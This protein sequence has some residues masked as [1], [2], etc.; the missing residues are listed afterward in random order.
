MKLRLRKQQLLGVFCISIILSIN[1]FSQNTKGNKAYNIISEH[2]ISCHNANSN[3]SIPDFTS[4]SIIRKWRSTIKEAILSAYMPPYRAS[5]SSKI[6]SENI[7]DSIEKSNLVTWLD[8]NCKM[9]FLKKKIANKASKNKHVYNTIVKY[10]KP[11]LLSPSN[12]DRF[13]RT[14]NL[15]KLSEASTIK[16]LNF[17]PQLR[18]YIHHVNFAIYSYHSKLKLDTS[19]TIEEIFYSKQNKKI[20]L[21]FSDTNQFKLR[22]Y[23]GWLPGSNEEL[24]AGAIGINLDS[25]NLIQFDIHYAS[26]PELVI[27][28]SYLSIDIQNGKS[29]QT[30]QSLSLGSGGFGTI[31]PQL[32]IPANTI[33]SF[34]CDIVIDKTISVLSVWPHMHLLGSY[35]KAYTIYNNDTLPLIEIPEWDFNWQ[36]KYQFK[37]PIQL[38]AGTRIRFEGTYDNT[39][40][41][42]RNPSN[43]PA[44]V[45]SG[46]LMNSKDEM[47]TLVI[48]YLDGKV[49]LDNCK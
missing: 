49:V 16:G 27:D 28:T 47:L 11:L 32:V 46:G 6:C 34:K 21:D 29:K 40:N 25:N 13:F 9:P 33:K 3:Y 26:I 37:Q 19:T 24:F 43:P 12:K 4:I 15:L 2:C 42:P 20:K 45:F 30:I 1:I 8:G 23:S 10:K 22:Y 35:F 48:T 5:S 7:L 17:S 39:S 14:Y 18:K 31:Y 38:A 36:L 41:N 44:S